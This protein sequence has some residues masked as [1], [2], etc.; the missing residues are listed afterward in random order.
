MTGEIVMAEPLDH[1]AAEEGEPSANARRLR[2]LIQIAAAGGTLLPI[3]NPNAK[4][5]YDYGALEAGALPDLKFLADRDYLDERFFDRVSIC[6]HCASH[7]LNLREVCPDCR[8]AHLADEML[9]HHYRC[10]YAGRTS[11]FV[12][13]AGAKGGLACPKC[14]RPLNHVGTE[15]DRLDN[16]FFCLDCG[17]SFQDPP[18]EAV[19]LDC[20]MR[21]P[22]ADLLSVDIFG[23][24]LTSLGMAAIAR[25]RLLEESSEALFIAD[26]RIYRP[27][28]IVELLEQ[29]ARRLKHFR[30]AFSVLLVKAE[31][32][33]EDADAG[34][35]M[36]QLLAR[37]RDRL[38]EIDLIGQLTRS[39]FVIVLPQTA[40]REAE[41]LRRQVLAEA[42]YPPPFAITAI[43]IAEPQDLGQVLAYLP[44]QASAR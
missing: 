4:S 37:L 33:G 38:R 40:Q 12:A 15:Y 39:I 7:R 19:C 18:V 29:E 20:A 44:R 34:G 14:G 36:P 32:R 11:E 27:T 8:S 35:P 22:A 6:P 26:Q 43:E 5:G 24:A 16:A 31:P 23:Y 10:G 1:V 21:S 41:L 30:T 2:L 42:G 9:L 17:T 25:A 13:E 3:G 28:V